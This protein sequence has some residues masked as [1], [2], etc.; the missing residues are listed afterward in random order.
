MSGGFKVLR[1]PMNKQVNIQ[2]MLDADAY[3]TIHYLLTSTD[4]EEYLED[5]EQHKHLTRQIVD[6][7]FAD[8]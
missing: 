5:L 8:E 1:N 6:E 2:D 7:Q 3:E 4:S